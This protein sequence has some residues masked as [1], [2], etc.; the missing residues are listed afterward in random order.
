MLVSV[1]STKYISG[2]ACQV[3]LKASNLSDTKPHQVLPQNEEK[4]EPTSKKACLTKV[5]H[6]EEQQHA[7]INPS[8]SI[9]NKSSGRPSIERNVGS[10]SLNSCHDRHVPATP[11]RLPHLLHNHLNRPKGKDNHSRKPLHLCVPH[12]FHRE[13]YQ[14]HPS[15]SGQFLLQHPP[16]SVL[17]PYQRGNISIKK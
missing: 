3:V 7:K 2:A 12:T 4:S 13:A 15:A 10:V 14:S 16:A 5:E 9:H 1:K 11:E 8:H 17:P 6:V